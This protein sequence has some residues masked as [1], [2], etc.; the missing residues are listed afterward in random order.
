MLTDEGGV[1]GRGAENKKAGEDVYAPPCI[2]K[3]IV[4]HS[5]VTVK[6]SFLLTRKGLWFKLFEEKFY[7]LLQINALPMEQNDFWLVF[8]WWK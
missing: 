5:A 1:W 3:K 8:A 4:C 7:E 6:L 2:S